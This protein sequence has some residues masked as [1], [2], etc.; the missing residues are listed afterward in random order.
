[1]QK[2][3]AFIQ[4]HRIFFVIV[5]VA[6]F[7]H[8]AAF[9]TFKHL[10]IKYPNAIH[11]TF[12]IS[13]GGFDSVQYATLAENILKYGN[14]SM[15]P[16]AHGVA[17]AYRT[18]GYP[19]FIAVIE[20]ISGTIDAVPIFQALLFVGAAFFMYMMA[21]SISP[22]FKKAALVAVALLMIDPMTFYSS[23]FICTES[24]YTFFFTGALYFVIKTPYKIKNYVIA[25]LFLGVSTLVRPSGYYMIIPIGLWMLWRIVKRGENAENRKYVFKLG[26]ALVFTAAIVVAP[27]YVRNG[28]RTGVY[29]LSSLEAINTIM[30]N[31]PMYLSYKSNYTR[32][33]DSI[34]ADLYKKA[35]NLTEDDLMDAKN[36]AKIKEVVWAE[37]R[38]NI[39]SY[40][41]FHMSKSI[42][43]FFSPGLKYET[44]TVKSFWQES[45]G[46]VW[47]PEKSLVNS[48]I[49]RRW[50][51]VFMWAFHNLFYLPESLFLL[52]IFIGG[53]YWCIA[54][55]LSA[56]FLI[57]GNILFLAVL[58]SPLSNPRYRVPVVPLMYLSGIIGL[59]MIFSVSKRFWNTRKAR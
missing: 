39:L 54:S 41:F 25:G 17:D 20:Y 47:H 2:I 40:G 30:F 49:D 29:S 24:L 51:D 56:S 59:M 26:V 52:A 7:L 31:M 36:S 43:F 23:T 57:F 13:G 55:R 10:S 9:F 27:W 33:I 37:L 53:L 18:P 38:P 8:I 46:K 42:N 35:G 6:M 48:F 50:K 1:M 5:C 32:S 15:Q 22:K 19:F 4:E 12:P 58:T 16:G 44:D 3:R 21:L 14:F 34:R 28:V 45:E 11:N